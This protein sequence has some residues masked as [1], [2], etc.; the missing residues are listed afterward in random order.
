MWPTR[1]LTFLQSR[2]RRGRYCC[3][4]CDALCERAD[5]TEL[6]EEFICPGCVAEQM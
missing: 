6:P 5:L 2:C 1:M 3:D 4:R